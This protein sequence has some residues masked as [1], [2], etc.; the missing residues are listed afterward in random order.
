MESPKKFIE[1]YI[2]NLTKTTI[3]KSQPLWDL[4]L[5]KRLE[6]SGD[7]IS[8]MSLLLACTRQI[9]YPS[10]LPTIPGKK[11]KQNENKFG[12]FRRSVMAVFWGLQMFWNTV[13]NGM[14]FMATALFLNNTDTPLRGPP[15]VEFTPRRFVW[16]AVSLDDI[17][18]IK[19]AMSTVS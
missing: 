10:A 12:W 4:H 14:M 9:S 3:D 17:K 6:F 7:D 2:S 5:L 19:N 16:R 11:K 8:L 1:D 15:G 13:V 18:L